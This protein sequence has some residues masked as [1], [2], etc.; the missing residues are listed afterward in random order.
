MSGDE[1]QLEES[2][3]DGE[4]ADGTTDVDRSEIDQSARDVE[5]LQGH[6]ESFDDAAGVTPTRSQQSRTPGRD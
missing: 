2:G 5:R 3:G 1:P 4:P 6:S